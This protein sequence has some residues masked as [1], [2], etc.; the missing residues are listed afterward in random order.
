[1][2]KRVR[3]YNGSGDR[4][5]TWLLVRGGEVRA[6]AWDGPLGWV[7]GWTVGEGGGY[8]KRVSGYYRDEEAAKAAAERGGL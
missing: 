5:F 7:A 2:W 6:Y 4:G 8:A 1:M 3:H